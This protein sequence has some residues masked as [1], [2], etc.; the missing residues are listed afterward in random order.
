MITAVCA[1][2]AAARKFILRVFRTASRAFDKYAAVGHFGR[3]LGR[4]A[5][6][7]CEHILKRSEFVLALLK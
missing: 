7:L 1:Y 2:I 3:R 5:L 4:I 6:G